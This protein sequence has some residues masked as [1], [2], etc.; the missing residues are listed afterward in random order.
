VRLFTETRARDELPHLYGFLD[1]GER[2]W[3]RLLTTVQ[4]VGARVALAILSVLPPD[5]LTLAIAAQDRAAITAADGVGPKL[6]TRLL[7]ELKDKTGTLGVSFDAGPA[8]TALPGIAG[9]AVSALVNLGYGRSEVVNVVA[10]LQADEIDL[11]TL[12][13]KAL[14]ELGA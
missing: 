13:R 9:D 7:S 3:F 11:G 14:K 10:K 2:D 6:A 8:I 5:K 1:A 4:G 12:I